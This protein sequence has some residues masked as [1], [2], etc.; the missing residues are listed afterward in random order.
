MCDY[1]NAGYL[2][3]RHDNGFRVIKQKRHIQR[4]KTS[5]KLSDC[6]DITVLM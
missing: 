3:Y 6:G 5:N 4:R 2:F 1:Y